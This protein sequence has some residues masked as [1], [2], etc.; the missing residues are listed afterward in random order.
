MNSNKMIKT[1]MFTIDKNNVIILLF[2]L[3]VTF[4]FSTSGFKL[5]IESIIF[6]LL[7]SNL[8]LKLFYRFD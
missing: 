2:L 3:F 1:L 4:T 7:L 6:F 5:I 8:I